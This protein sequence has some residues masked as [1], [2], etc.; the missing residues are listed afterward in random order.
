MIVVRC[1]APTIRPIF[2]PKDK[3]GDV[4]EPAILSTRFRHFS[5][6]I[7]NRGCFQWL[8]MYTK[9]PHLVA[10]SVSP[11]PT[12]RP[13]TNQPTARVLAALESAGDGDQHVDVLGSRDGQLR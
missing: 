4:K 6:L 13:N 7:P 11:T 8:E 9:V 12:N 3:I 2:S 5:A 10:L 1:V